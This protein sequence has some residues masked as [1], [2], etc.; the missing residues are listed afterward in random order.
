[1]QRLG[2]GKDG[3]QVRV[4]ENNCWVMSDEFWAV[5]FRW[6]GDVD[7]RQQTCGTPPFQSPLSLY[8]S[9]ALQAAIAFS[10]SSTNNDPLLPLR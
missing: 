2:G 7:S 4:R 3:Q 10:Q 9:Y 1:M 6:E 8:S 5:G